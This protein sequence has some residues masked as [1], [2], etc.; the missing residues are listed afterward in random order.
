LDDLLRSSRNESISD[1]AQMCV[2]SLA[3][4]SPRELG[5]PEKTWTFSLLAS[6][7]KEHCIESGYPALGKIRK[8]SL[9][10]LL[11]ENKIQ[12]QKVR[13]FMTSRDPEFETK[14]ENILLTYKIVELLQAKR[15][16]GKNSP[17]Q[18]PE[19]PDQV[20]VSYDKKPEAKL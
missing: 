4:T 9:S 11:D 10:R 5:K 2:C 8:G 12:S 18:L 14:S 16:R 13:Y 15:E 7:I 17:V 1:Q 6:Y 19:E 3:F 20:I